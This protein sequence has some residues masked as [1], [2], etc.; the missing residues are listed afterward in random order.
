MRHG[1]TCTAKGGVLDQ[2]LNLIDV[3]AF[4]DIVSMGKTMVGKGGAVDG[5]GQALGDS[6]AEDVVVFENWHIHR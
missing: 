3:V 6:L 5:W 2:W 4:T 1:D